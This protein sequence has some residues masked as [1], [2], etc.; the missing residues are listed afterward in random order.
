MIYAMKLNLVEKP[1]DVNELELLAEYEDVFCEDLTKLPPS[2][3]VD[4][5][6]ELAR[7]QLIAKRPYQ[8][9]F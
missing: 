5:A 6:I 3:E 7:A 1:K 9:L 8:T 2:R 4:H